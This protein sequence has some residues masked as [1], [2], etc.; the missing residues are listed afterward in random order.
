MRSLLVAFAA[1]ILGVAPA[2]AA[3][4]PAKPAPE[5]MRVVLVHGDETGC[6]PHCAAWI[7]AEGTITSQTPAAFQRL[8]GARGF[9]KVPVVIR[10][11]GGD[12]EAAMAIGRLIRAHKLDVVVGRTFFEPCIPGSRD[13]DEAAG[14]GLT[15]STSS[16]RAFCASACSEILAAGTGRF[17]PADAVVGVHQVVRTGTFVRKMLTFSVRRRL[18]GGVPV[19]VSRRLVRER[20][21]SSQTR[22]VPTS[23]AY[24]DRIGRYFRAMGIGEAIMPI[25]EATPSA[26]IHW[27]TREELDQCGLATGMVAPQNVVEMANLALHPRPVAA[28]APPPAPIAP[29]V[30]PAATT[31]QPHAA[32]PLPARLSAMGE[33]QV[34]RFQGAPVTVFVAF[35]WE[36]GSASVE[37]SATPLVSQ[38]EVPLSDLRVLVRPASAPD[39]LLAADHAGTGLTALMPKSAFCALAADPRLKIDVASSGTPAISGETLYTSVGA[40]HDI[41]PILGA[42]CAPPGSLASAPP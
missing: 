40:F 38:G 24:Y 18:V 27:M 12:V 9:E 7:S 16:W 3:K 39:M 36:R 22:Q 6:A 21:V 32:A 17:V 8:I 26:S 14:R 19:E 34:G 23:Q 33:A 10:S 42:A 25:M 20:V 5:T 35:A 37:I 4:P 28:A 1:L 15:G 29:A 11:R 13:C 41:R 30:V 2:W 31:A